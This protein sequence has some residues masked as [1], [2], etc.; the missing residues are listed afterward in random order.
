MC[1]EAASDI[2]RSVLQLI[3]WS[4]AGVEV[5]TQF[6]VLGTLMVPSAANSG[7]SGSPAASMDSFGSPKGSTS[8]AA[9]VFPTDPQLFQRAVAGDPASAYNFSSWVPQVRFPKEDTS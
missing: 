4:G 8:A 6:D 3:A 2:V 9:S 7:A 5:Q 1:I